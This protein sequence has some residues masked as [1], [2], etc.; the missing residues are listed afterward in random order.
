MFLHVES[1]CAAKVGAALC[2]HACLLYLV[3]NLMLCG[4][5]RLQRKLNQGP[6]R[7]WKGVLLHAAKQHAMSD[8]MLNNLQDPFQKP[9]NGIAAPLLSKGGWQ[10][11]QGGGYQV[12][13]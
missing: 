9:Q 7:V 4:L 1:Q 6:E 5:R 11:E 8:R 13:S 12:F 2:L 3:C 10:K